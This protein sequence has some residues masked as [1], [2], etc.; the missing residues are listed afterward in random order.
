MAP[1][2][3]KSFSCK[4]KHIKVD[5]PA[6]SL[7]HTHKYTHA[8]CQAVI[9]TCKQTG[10]FPCTPQKKHPPVG[11]GDFGLDWY[12]L[13][14]KKEWKSH[15]WQRKQLDTKKTGT[16]REPATGQ[17]TMRWPTCQLLYVGS[18]SEQRA[19]K[20]FCFPLAYRLRGFTAIHSMAR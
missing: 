14:A 18:A 20:S 13:L 3:S 4:Y 17:R 5:V 9:L 11:N 2:D 16:A 10:H 12:R 8:H 6:L 19:S 1:L 15:F 7:S